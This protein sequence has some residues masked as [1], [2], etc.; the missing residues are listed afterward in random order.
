MNT[1]FKDRFL[2]A[3]SLAGDEK[4][5]GKLYDKYVTPIYR[6]VFFRVNNTEDAEDL[7]AEVFLKTWQYLASGQKTVE[8]FKA[9]LY[10]I[11]NNLVVDYY[12]QSGHELNFLDQDQW[13]QIVDLTHNL[14]EEIRKKDDIN[15][16]YQSINKLNDSEK[17][18]LIMRYVDDLSV[19][20]IAVIL[21]KNS[22]TIRV[23]LH[24]ATKA[25]KNIIKGHVSQ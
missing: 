5:F 25:L 9:L 13:L 20:E 23:A 10:R 22:G 2:V 24:R 8:N 21:D 6:F 15:Q 17:E 18:L 1:N 16:L 19:K 11:A 3:G 12:R 14:E 7:T 4:A